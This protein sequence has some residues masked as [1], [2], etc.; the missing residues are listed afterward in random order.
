MTSCCSRRVRTLS[1]KQSILAARQRQIAAQPG[2]RV[3]SY[4]PEIKGTTVT[5]DG[6]AFQWGVMTGTY[7]AAKGTTQTQL[8][9]KLLRVLK[10]QPDGSWKAAIGMTN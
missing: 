6:W 8:R 9:M 4:V 3:L 1:G 7:V 2:F 5:A 10:K